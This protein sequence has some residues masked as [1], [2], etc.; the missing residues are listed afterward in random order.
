MK[1]IRYFA[2]LLMLITGLLHIVPMFGEPRDPN[3]LPML[4]FGIVYF[5]VGVLLIL[6]I[7]YSEIS[8]IIFPLIGLGIGFFVVGLK[9]WDTLLSIMFTIDTIVV[10]CCIVLLLNKYKEKA[11]SQQF[12]LR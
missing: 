9:N 2:A 11:T 7:N 12:T 1:T 8:G 3:A 10:I 5:A 4:A 6:K